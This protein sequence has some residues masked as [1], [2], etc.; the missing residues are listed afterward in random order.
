MVIDS[1]W[2]YPLKGGA[3]MRVDEWE[4]DSFGPVHDRR[5][6]VVDGNGGFLSQRGDP[7]LGQVVPALEADQLVLRS[8]SAGELRL[9]LGPA[10]GGEAARVRV[11][12]DEVA[13]TDCGGDAA[14]FM[15][16]HLGREARV[17]YMPETAVRP[18]PEAYAPHG[19]R[20]SFADAFP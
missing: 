13:A 2:V 9:P 8:A 17:V 20:V 1:L 11:W 15:T 14:A 19:G 6:M 7:M 3:G 5:W 12:A 4:L 10:A 18:L 16:R